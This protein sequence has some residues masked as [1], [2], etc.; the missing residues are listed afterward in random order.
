MTINMNTTNL[1]IRQIEGFL[2]GT[3]PFTIEV[4]ES[5]EEK[6]RWIES[7]LREARYLLEKRKQKSLIRK[8]L[9]RC[10]GYTASHIDHLI[11]EY[12]MSGKIKRKDRH[13][14]TE[15]SNF[16]TRADI[17]LLAEVSEAYFHPNGRALKEVL[18]DMYQVYD[19]LR[20]ERLSHL[21][22]SRLYDFRKTVTYQN[23]VLTYTKTKSASVNIG[24]RKK[25]RAQ[26]Q[27]G[28]LRVDSVHQGDLDKEKGVYHIHLVDE[29]TQFDVQLA[30]SGI[31]E[32]FL[33]PVLEEALRL[34]PFNI[35]NFHSDNGSE[36]INRMVA[37]LLG[38]LLINQTKSRS[39]RTNDNALIEGKHAAT[40][41][42]VYG[43]VH[44]PRRYADA[45]NDFNREY[46]IPF[47]NYHRKCA[48]PTE[49]VDNKGK[50]RKVYKEYATPVEKL[51]S[52]ALVAEYL[53]EGVT[54]ASLRETQAKDSHFEAAKKMQIAR[55]KL[56][57][58]FT[59]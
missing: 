45:I 51:L 23:A 13:C 49:I 3:A 33:L 44:I 24:E 39:L 1:T 35:I 58:T 12:R 32:Q 55:T 15:Y 40:V 41:R 16:Y 56:F 4:G 2:K 37:E 42:P 10:T 14:Y 18:R 28:Y 31:S 8:F 43:R 22:V 19:D 54:I 21:S 48:F 50:V 52:L 7:I 6:Y 57:K 47:L 27:P 9:V 38:K 53:R 59:K 5:I 36:Y 17:V 11:Y 20:F 25:P 46:L 34:F 26:G 30:T 29:V